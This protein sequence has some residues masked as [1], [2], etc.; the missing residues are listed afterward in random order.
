MKAA[1]QSQYGDPDVLHVRDI[2]RPTPGPRE[3]L[4]QVHASSVTQGDRRLRA[5]DFPGIMGPLGRLMSGVFTPR[6]QVGGT[7]FAGRVV[8]A[9]A[10]VSHLQAGD[11]VFGMAMHGAYAE[12]LT[13][14]ADAP[15]AKMPANIGYGEAAAI[16]YGA[17]T[18]LYFLRDLARLSGGE[19]VLVIGASGGVGRMAVQ[20]AKHYGAHVTGLCSSAAAK[21]VRGL[22]ADEVLDYTR[23]DVR[24]SSERWDVIFDTTQGSHFAGLR[25]Q[26][27]AVGRYLSLYVTV[28]ALWEMLVTKVGSGPRMLVGVALGSPAQVEDIRLL[29]EQGVLRASVAQRFALSEIVEAHRCLESPGLLGSVVIDVVAPANQQ[30]LDMEKSRGTARSAEGQARFSGRFARV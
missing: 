2:A 29:V 10:Q 20:L 4:I 22:G 23:V 26:L 6:H 9:G 11:D 1:I 12:Y 28:R 5:A 8:E 18:A 19:R 3:V 14:S 17:G 7:A 15:V 16:P 27:T 24:A 25:P 30:R 21:T 13:L